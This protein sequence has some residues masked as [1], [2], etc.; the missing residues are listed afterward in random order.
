MLASSKETASSR[1]SVNDT[2]AE[3]EDDTVKKLL[4]EDSVTSLSVTDAKPTEKEKETSMS[5]SST[6]P[7]SSTSPEVELD[8]F[9][10]RKSNLRSRKLTIDTKISSL[11]TEKSEEGK[12]VQASH[13]AAE[14]CTPGTVVSVWGKT[15]DQDAYQPFFG[16]KSLNFDGVGKFGDLHHDIGV[17][18]QRGQKPHAP[19]Q[20]DFFVLQK[21]GWLMCGVADGHGQCGHDVSRF[22]QENLPQFV[23]KHFV[24]DKEDWRTSASSA[25]SDVTEKM[26]KDIPSKCSESGATASV[27]LIKHDESDSGFMHVHS[28]FVGDSTIVYARR[29]NDASWEVAMESENHRPD[30]ED[31]LK[32]IKAAGGEVMISSD[33]KNPSRLRVPSGDMAMSRALGDIDAHAHGLIAEPQFPDPIE[34]KD[35]AQHLILICSDG[36]WDVIEPKEA[37]TI[38]SKFA[39]DDSQRAAERLAA[40]AQSR[41]QQQETSPG[42]IDDITVILIRPRVSLSSLAPREGRLSLSSVPESLASS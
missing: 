35:D 20:D 1:T 5:E 39:A 42:V 38:V 36:V 2:P 18:C 23:I 25:F 11:I 15:T 41:W 33:P 6:R 32:R 21:E 12:Y 8:V 28:A 22:V 30:R 14:L 31:E 7:S 10:R 16:G 40:K 27:V 9:V 24:T 34:M 13:P 3:P 37:V 4:K 26:K 19:N 29:K 17:H